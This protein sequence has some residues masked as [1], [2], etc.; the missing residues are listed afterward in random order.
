MSGGIV[1]IACRMYDDAKEAITSHRTAV[2]KEWMKFLGNR[3]R[4]VEYPLDYSQLPPFTKW[5]E[6]LVRSHDFIDESDR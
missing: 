5:F 2:R 4:P 3:K 1:G 6:T